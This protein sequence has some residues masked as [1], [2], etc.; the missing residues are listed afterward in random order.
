MHPAT[1]RTLD[2]VSL[3][4]GAGALDGRRDAAAHRPPAISDHGDPATCSCTLC[5][6]YRQAYRRAYLAVARR[7]AAAP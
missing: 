4:A 3:S 7:E 2:F 1:P 6:A 5:R